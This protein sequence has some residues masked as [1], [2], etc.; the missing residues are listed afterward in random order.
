MPNHRRKTRVDETGRT[1]PL[2]RVLDQSEQVQYKVEAAATDLSGVNAVLKKEVV[3]GSPLLEVVNALDQ[4]VVVEAR[5]QE[6]ADELV[7]VNDALAAEIDDRIAVEHEL[8][9]SKA[10]LSVSRVEASRARH[11]S[12]HDPLTGLPNLT[13]FKDRLKH[14]IAQARR[15]GWLL[16]VMFVDLDEFKG[17]NDAHGHD[18][19]DAVIRLV[20]ERLSEFVR[21]GDTVAR[22]SGDEFLFLM[23]EAKDIDNARTMAQ[24]IIALIAAPCTIQGIALSIQASVGLALYPA[25]GKT[26]SE[27]LKQ[28]DL[29]MYAAKRQPSGAVLPNAPD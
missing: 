11:D 20:A 16:A 18:V 13:L 17:V 5:V 14:A 3:K 28:A 8:I 27:L 12:L 15:K 1:A 26:V 22:R 2:A 29:A 23:L 21:D 9:E 10:A 24:R 4:S 7:A 19:G 6:A 25:H